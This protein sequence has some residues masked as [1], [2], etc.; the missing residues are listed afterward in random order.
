MNAPSS[1]I[2]ASVP[3]LEA[4]DKISG[5]ARYLDD[6][7]RPGM[8]YA[9]VAQSP[10]AHANILRIDTTEA[11]KLPGVKAIVTGADVKFPRAGGVLKDESMVARGK[12]RY[13]GEPVAAVAARDHATAQLAAQLI[14][15]EYEPL[16]AVLS[17]DEA[18]RPGAPL[19]HED[20]AQLLQDHRRRR[21]R[22]RRLR[23][24]E[25]SEGDVETR[26][27]QCD[28][29]RRGHLGD[30]GPAPRLHGDERLRGRGRRRRQASRSPRPA[31]RCTT[32]SIASPKSSASRW[33][34]S[35]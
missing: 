16:P 26:L 20:F 9:A 2:G 17:I 5:D 7:V 14:E 35:A 18:L 31:S 6:L 34:R 24:S 13:V 4:K 19:L 1:T 21:A 28:V 30:P 25:L 10:H 27:S 22:Q 23:E 12:V 8:L 33:R 29:V 15:V 3:R 32:S 11:A